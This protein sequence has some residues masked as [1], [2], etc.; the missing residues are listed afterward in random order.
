MKT[1][2]SEKG[3]IT[4]P[5]ALRHRLALTPGT[6]LEF[7]EEKGRLIGEKKTPDHALEKWLGTG[8][9]PFGRNVDDYIRQC[10][11]G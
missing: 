3:Q 10:R 4:I 8:K 7:H 9:L 5:Q 1:I 2:V 6:V 11:E